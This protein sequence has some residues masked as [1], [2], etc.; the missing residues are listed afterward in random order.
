[1]ALI[2]K[3]GE[4][5]TEVLLIRRAQ[6]RGDPWSGHVALPGGRAEEVDADSVA[7]ARRE[8]LEEIGLDLQGSRML[9]RLA[10]QWTKS[11]RRWAPFAIVP[12]AFA[13]EEKEVPTLR[14]SEEVTRA[15]WLPLAE[16]QG[17]RLDGRHAWKLGPLPLH[18][19]CWNHDGEV[20]WG[21]TH[22]I[23]TSLLARL[24]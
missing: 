13:L 10:P 2:L 17:G 14:F 18:L 5:G 21:M 8:T 6:R 15:F 11:P 19:P 22:R 23:L 20:V 1:M 16:V 4:Q 3:E 24:R 7:T 12:V 9:G